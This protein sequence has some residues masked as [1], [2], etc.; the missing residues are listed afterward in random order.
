[1]QAHAREPILRA[2]STVKRPA[3]KQPLKRIPAAML[4]TRSIISQAIA[5]PSAL[6]FGAE[7]KRSRYTSGTGVR[8]SSIRTGFGQP[9]QGPYARDYG[10]LIRLD[11]LEDSSRKSRSNTGRM[12]A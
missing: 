2:S 3:L 12:T 10:K 7:R 5:T 6:P 4:R 9:A 1:M 8:R 11:A